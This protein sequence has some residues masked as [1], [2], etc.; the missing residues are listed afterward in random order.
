MFCWVKRFLI[1]PVSEDARNHANEP[2]EPIGL[3][4]GLKILGPDNSARSKVFAMKNPQPSP[5]YLGEIS[6]VWDGETK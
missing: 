1:M 6:L 4:R 2:V 5:G 3:Y